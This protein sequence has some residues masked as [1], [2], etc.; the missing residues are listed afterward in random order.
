MADPD[1]EDHDD[2][3]PPAEPST[4]GLDALSASASRYFQTS[5]MSAYVSSI[6]GE[7]F[8]RFDKQLEP[9]RAMYADTF[10]ILKVSAYIAR[11]GSSCLSN[12]WKDSP[13][14]ELT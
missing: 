7:S 3:D 2:T 9:F 11:N 12:R 5:A 8:Q 6:A 10:R 14:I 13:A 1:E 4:N